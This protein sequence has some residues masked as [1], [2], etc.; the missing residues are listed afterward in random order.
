VTY[1]YFARLFYMCVPVFFLGGAI[2]LDSLGLFQY[3]GLL[4]VLIFVLALGARSLLSC[5][6]CK[7]WVGQ[8]KGGV[9][10]PWFGPKCRY[11]NSDL[12]NRRISFKRRS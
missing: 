6:V 3:F 9:Y 12:T 4:M 10:W 7:K 2:I 11:C 8:S 1:P 5:P